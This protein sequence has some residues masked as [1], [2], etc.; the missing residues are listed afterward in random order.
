MPSQPQ[1][2]GLTPKVTR[3]GQVFLSLQTARTLPPDGFYT[4][5]LT[6]LQR[7]LNSLMSIY[8]SYQARATIVNLHGIS[9]SLDLLS[10]VPAPSTFLQDL[11]KVLLEYNWGS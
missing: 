3:P 5:L 2:G 7:Q 6:K 10:F 9:R 4:L 8:T 1:Y 11:R